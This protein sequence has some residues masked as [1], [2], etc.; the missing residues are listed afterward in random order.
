VSKLSSLTFTHS[1]VMEGVAAHL[2]GAAAQLRAVAATA[3]P[4]T[5]GLI[6]RHYLTGDALVAACLA[7]ADAVDALAA[8]VR[9]AR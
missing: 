9:S 5:A 6:A 3:G 4:D 1:A 7:E 2:D 8:E